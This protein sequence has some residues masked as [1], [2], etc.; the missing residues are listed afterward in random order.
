MVTEQSTLRTHIALQPLSSALSVTIRNRKGCFVQRI[1]G[2]LGNIILKNAFLQTEVR[3]RNSV[4]MH[5]NTHFN[6]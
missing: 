5:E 6:V 1:L 2:K 4:Y 3:F